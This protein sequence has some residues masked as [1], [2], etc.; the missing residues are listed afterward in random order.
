MRRLIAVGLVLGSVVLAGPPARGG[1]GGI[2]ADLVAGGLNGP[3]AFTFAPDGRIFYGERFTGE[4]RI[5][6]PATST[7]TLFFTIPGV[8]TS[9]EQGLLGL[10][11][12]P[13]YPTRAAIFAYA[14][15]NVSGSDRN[16]IIR[17]RDSG[18]V[19]SQPRVIW[20]EDV[21]AAS[22]HNG[23]RILFGPDGQLFAVV[24]DAANPA[25]A[26]NLDNDAGKIL[27]MTDRGQPPPDN[28]FAG[29]LVW[30]YGERNSFGFTFDPETG[31]MWEMQNGPECNDEIN[32]PESGDNLAWGPNET[33]SSPPPPPKNTNQD[34][35][36]RVLPI[37][38][39]TPT[40][41]PVG[42]SFC[43]GCGL[44][45]SEGTMFFG[46]FN[47]TDIRQAVLT[48]DRMGIDSITTVYSHSDSLLSMERGP[49]GTIYFS[50][51]TS[52]WKL[53]QTQ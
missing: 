10:A 48:A 44:A 17:I 4:I 7:D 3:A 51:F 1:A 34:G 36:D 47:T 43:D 32:R 53:V 8:Q 28:P 18:G 19:G 50:D 25:N 12:H 15:R 23:G 20:T 40:T 9:G 27:R 2:G 45:G 49:D 41:A 6:D 38:F 31:S 26:Q 35:P 33:C 37:A 46:E 22:I 14:T 30:A 29:S 42:N 24:G 11:L 16:Q 5:Y 39:F 21:V 13:M 52:I